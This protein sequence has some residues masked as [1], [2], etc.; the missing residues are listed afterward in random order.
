MKNRIVLLL[1]TV[2]SLLLSTLSGFGQD[3]LQLAE[4]VILCT[5]RK[6]YIA[7]EQIGFSCTCLKLKDAA[8]AFSKVLFVELVSMDGQ[9]IVSQKH[10][11]DVKGFTEG[12]LV[13]P[14]SV[15]SGMFLLKAY[16]KHLEAKGPNYFGYVL[17]RVINAQKPQLNLADKQG[18]AIEQSEGLN[19][20]QLAELKINKT[21]FKKREQ[22]TASLV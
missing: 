4:K 12:N 6:L 11:I 19:D 16:T 10:P 21:L 17:I 14:A 18:S 7:G 22:G 1:A 2:S 5:D 9:R 15:S 13:I 8:E 20:R 3:E